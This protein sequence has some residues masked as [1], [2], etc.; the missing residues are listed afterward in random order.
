MPSVQ[1][2]EMDGS[3]VELE[4]TGARQKMPTPRDQTRQQVAR[5]RSNSRGR[6]THAKRTG[7]HLTTDDGTPTRQWADSEGFVDTPIGKGPATAL[8]SPRRFSDVGAVG[9]LRAE[10]LPPPLLTQWE[11]DQADR[12]HQ[13]AMEQFYSIEAGEPNGVSTP[14]DDAASTS[15]LITQET[16]QVDQPEDHHDQLTQEASI[17]NFTLQPIETVRLRR[18]ETMAEETMVRD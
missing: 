2:N 5:T 16:S 17:G 14:N 8:L 9:G 18:I 4:F 6:L 3:M 1:P 12:P 10:L 13:E 7:R 15:S 11:N